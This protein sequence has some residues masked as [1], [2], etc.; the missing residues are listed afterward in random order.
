M[1]FNINLE[2]KQKQNINLRQ[3]KKL[4]ILEASNF[5]LI[6]IINNELLVNPCLEEYFEEDNFVEI[7]SE[8]KIIEENDYDFFSNLYTYGNNNKKQNSFEN[9]FSIENLA[10]KER[11]LEEVL[12]EQLFFYKLEEKEY[13][14]G[15]YLIGNIDRKGYLDS[16]SYEILRNKSEFKDYAPKILNL[17][18]SFEPFG[19]GGRDVIEVIS[20]QLSN[21]KNISD[22]ERKLV[23]KVICEDFDLILNKKILKLKKKFRLKDRE[24]KRIYEILSNITINPGVNFQEVYELKYIIPDI[25]VGEDQEISLNNQGIKGIKLNPYYKSEIR[26]VLL[27]E[28]SKKYIKEKLREGQLFI[29]FLSNRRETLYLITKTIIRFQRDFFESGEE[30]LYP[31]T[32]DDIAKTLDIDI[33]TVSRGI[34][35]KYLECK[36]GIYPYKYFFSNRVRSN[37]SINNYDD[38]D[39]EEIEDHTGKN[40]ILNQNKVSNK[41]VMKKLSEIVENEDKKKPLSDEKIKERLEELGFHISRRTVVKYREKL[42]IL[43]SSRRKDIR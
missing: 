39:M 1:D 20:I 10:R 6:E 38:F 15:R 30:Y 26:N 36:F 25:I 27:D 28:S 33:S 34:R 5:E 16:N 37:S 18:Q 40:K 7:T 17:I 14:I 19:V 24:V 23:K 42:G 11:T 31:M 22:E 29:D 9:D 32:L 12:L 2:Q 8:D 3:I 35:G 4:K 41:V 43:S 21:L 13:L